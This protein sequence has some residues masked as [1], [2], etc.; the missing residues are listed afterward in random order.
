[1]KH[2]N[3]IIRIF[4]NDPAKVCSINE[5]SMLLSMPYGTMY[6]YTQALIK[7]GVLKS[8]IKGKATLCSLN[9]ESQKA[10]ELL[11]LISV[12]IKEDFSKKQGV[13]SRAL[14]ELAKRINKKTYYS[15]FSIILFGSTAKGTSRE[16][17]DIDLFVI[18]P[19]KNKHDETIENECNALRM[20][21]GRDVNPIIAEPRMYINMLRDKE[22]N[23][24][25]QII[26]DKIIYFGANKFWELT[27]EGFK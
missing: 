19:S 2:D 11:S 17:S 1:M 9:Y 21:Y 6:N 18:S 14:D 16:K 15:I 7:D 25:K 5:M 24:A 26:R 13:L 27:I 3:K 8:N 23:A 4:Y 20:S 22:E 10:I 12:S